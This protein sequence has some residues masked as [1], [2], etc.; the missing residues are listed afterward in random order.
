MSNNKPNLGDDHWS[1]LRV[2][3][4]SFTLSKLPPL[5]LTNHEQGGDTTIA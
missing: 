3:A 2:N 1:T 4:V 5:Y